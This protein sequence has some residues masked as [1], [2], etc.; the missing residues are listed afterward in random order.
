MSKEPAKANAYEA[1]REYMEKEAAQ[2]LIGGDRHQLLLTAV[3]IVFP[4]EGHSTI[5]NLSDSMVRD[6]DP[7]GVA[8][9]ITRYV[10]RSSEG[11]FRIH[12]PV[13]AEKQSQKTFEGFVLSEGFEGPGKQQPSLLVSGFQTGEKL[14]AEHTAPD[15]HRQEKS[16]ARMKPVLVVRRKATGGNHSMNVEMILQSFVPSC[17]ER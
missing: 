1:S 11:S 5:G 4:T 9:Q 14:A 8:R 3:C 2:K 12:D 16:V 7:M 10:R 6:G 15:F 17:E 13:V